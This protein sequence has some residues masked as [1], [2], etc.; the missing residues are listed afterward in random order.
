[1]LSSENSSDAV[2][3]VVDF[4]CSQVIDPKSPF[5][6]A[7]EKHSNANTPGYSPPEIV[8]KGKQRDIV[9]HPSVDMFAIGVIVYIM[10]TGVHPFDLDGGSSDAEINSRVRNREMPPLRNSPITQHLSPSSIELIEKLIEWNPK[11]RL[12]AGKCD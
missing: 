6:D 5:Y 3:K 7:E 10:L 2:I 1:M 4:G 11:K 12:T 8:E 9:L